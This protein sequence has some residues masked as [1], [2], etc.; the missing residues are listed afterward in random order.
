MADLVGVDDEEMQARESAAPRDEGPLELLSERQRDHSDAEGPAVRY[1]SS[2]SRERA[3]HA[4][5]RRRLADHAPTAP[6]NRGERMAA[7]TET[8]IGIRCPWARARLEMGAAGSGV[9]RPG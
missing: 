8:G 3:A 6:T 5:E 9:H 7:S 1:E 4:A 2:S